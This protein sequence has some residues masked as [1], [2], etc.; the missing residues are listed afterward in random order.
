MDFKPHKSKLT[1]PRLISDGMV[2]QR[3]AEVRIWGWAEPGES[4]SVKFSDMHYNTQA[5]CDGRWEVFLRDLKAGGPYD[6]EIK[7]VS[8]KITVRNILVGEVWIC[9]GQSNMELPMARVKDQYPGEMINC[10][11]PLIR[12]FNVSMSYDFNES[13]ED[14]PE[15]EWVSSSPQ[16]ISEF[17]AVG[18]FFAKALFERYHIPVGFIRAAIGGSP[19]ESW[20]SEEALKTYPHIMQDLQPYKDDSYVEK[21]LKFDAALTAAWFSSLDRND[22]GLNSVVP[23]YSEELDTSAWSTMN[24]PATFEKEGLR[25]F[26]GVI[27][28]RKEID[29]PEEMLNKPVRLW[30]GRIVDSDRTYVNGEFVGEVT[31]QYPPRKYDI[32]AGLLKKGKNLIAVRIICNNGL[33]EIIPD[34]PYRLFTEDC[35][36]DLTGEWKYMVGASCG[37]LPNTTFVQWQPTGLYNGMLAP[38]TRYTVKGALWYQGEANIPRPFEYSSLMRTLIEDWRKRWGQSSFPFIFVQ[39]P[40]Y[41]KPDDYPAESQWAELREAQLQSL[42]I[43]DTA[44][45]ITIDLGEWNDIHPLRKKE[46]G[47]RLAMAAFSTAYGEKITASGPIYRDVQLMGSKIVISFNNIGNGLMTADGCEPKHFAVAGSDNKFLWAK[48]KIEGDKVIVWNEE[49]AEPRAVRYAWA[50]NPEGAN[51]VNTEG[52]PASPFRAEVRNL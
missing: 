3:E 46:V 42:D 35:S 13:F 25:N 29:V 43:P 1:L 48:A 21:T 19:I 6:M 39:L 28:F 32:P 41:G 27:W 36:I 8:D 38:L 47:E 20:I 4:I 7:T 49:I 12:T 9:S 2:L 37:P 10:E 26:N 11:N 30:L 40:N 34:K 16:T 22:K 44:M 24:W 52:L 33:G 17:S 15:G 18:Y 31:Y 5:A 50:D 23:W 14:L 51:L 45:A